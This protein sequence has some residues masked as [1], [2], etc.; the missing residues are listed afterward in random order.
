MPP[1]PE[2]IERLRVLLAQGAS[3]ACRQGLEVLRARFRQDATA[4]GPEAIADLKAL[5]RDLEAVPD[6]EAALKA[7]F[8]YDTFRPGQ[9]AI[10][11]AVLAG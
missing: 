4:F 11:E 7:T 1:V 2:E 6:L 10:I 8:G 3:A 9:R 5:A